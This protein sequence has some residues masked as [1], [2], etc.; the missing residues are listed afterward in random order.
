MEHTNMVR[1]VDRLGRIGIPIKLKRD[2][3][4]EMGD[5]IEIFVESETIILK[6]VHAHQPCMITGEVSDR[7]IEIAKGK[8]V[9]SPDRIEKLLRELRK[10]TTRNNKIIL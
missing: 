8:L 6:K 5:D 10:Y 9:L 4:I 2:L 7:N 3:N 1:K